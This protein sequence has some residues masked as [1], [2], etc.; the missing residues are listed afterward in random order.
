MKKQN[1]KCSNLLKKLL[2]PYKDFGESLVYVPKVS[3]HKKSISL[4]NEPC[5]AWP[6]FIDLNSNELHY[7]RFM[8]SL[9]RC[10][11]SYTTLDDL[12][13]RS[14]WFN[15]ISRIN[16]S[17]TLPRHISYNSKCKFDDRKCNVNQKFELK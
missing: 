2:L 15:M 11:N 3:G 13:S 5:L 17:K 12:S 8:V 4:N 9:Y 16:E 6:I 1:I 14:W 7:Y 10:N